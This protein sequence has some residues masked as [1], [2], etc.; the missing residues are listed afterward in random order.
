MTSSGID[1]EDV[2]E[3]T[4]SAS[5]RVRTLIDEYMAK[6]KQN[7]IETF[8]H[9]SLPADSLKLVFKLSIDGIDHTINNAEKEVTAH[10]DGEIFTTIEV[11]DEA[12]LLLISDDLPLLEPSGSTV[13]KR[14]VQPHLLS[15]KQDPDHLLLL[16]D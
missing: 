10:E 14:D 7:D 5:V 8:T 9:V 2:A 13:K 15:L 12:N 1:S 6:V 3:L 16:D 11:N 4:A